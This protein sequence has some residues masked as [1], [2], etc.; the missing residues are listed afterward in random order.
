MGKLIVI[1][2]LDGS[3]KT[4]Q[5]S[6]LSS[7]LGLCNVPCRTISFPDYDE[8][9]AAL[10]TMYLGGEF[11]DKPADVNAYA[12]SSFY[13]VDRF[14]S[15]HRH[16]RDSYKNG[17]VIIANR[18]TTSN[19]PYQMPKLPH[20]EWDVYLQWLEDYE[21]GKLALPRPDMVIYLDVPAEQ[22]QKLISSRYQG[23]E[24]RKDIHERTLA[25]QLECREA[26]LYA[27]ERFG[28]KLI[29]CVS[30]GE[31]RTVEEISNEIRQIIGE[32]RLIN[33]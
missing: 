19:I 21:Y 27:C 23:D 24:S 22:A 28:W 8:P 17:D 25:Y 29:S 7:W 2:G 4:T 20:E 32:S 15:F 30:D 1:E 5:T 14:A 12:A 16:W 3:G 13:A 26:A 9:S 11:G 10:V 6:L 31:M 33:A 18:Y